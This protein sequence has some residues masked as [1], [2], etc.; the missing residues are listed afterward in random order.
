MLLDVNVLKKA[1][2]HGKDPGSAG[3]DGFLFL[4][5]QRARA[6]FPIVTKE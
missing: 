5:R 6:R 4:S 1:D 3:K 2:R